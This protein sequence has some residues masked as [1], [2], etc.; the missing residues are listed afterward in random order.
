MPGG[1]TCRCVPLGGESH[2]VPQVGS[3]VWSSGWG[4]TCSPPGGVPGV[5]LWVG[6]HVQSPRW[7]ARCGPLGGCAGFGVIIVKTF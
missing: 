4:V 3:Q 6:S 1:I 5:V 2:A 7:G